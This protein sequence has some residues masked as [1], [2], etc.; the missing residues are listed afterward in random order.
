MKWN[1]FIEIGQ[2]HVVKAT[3]ETRHAPKVIADREAELLF[4]PTLVAQPTL[5]PTMAPTATIIH[6]W[7]LEHIADSYDVT[8]G[9]SNDTWASGYPSDASKLINSNSDV[10]MV[11]NDNTDVNI[12]FDLGAPRL[13]QG[14]YIQSWYFTSI[15]TIEVGV[16]M[17]DG[18]GLKDD[19]END[20][21]TVPDDSTVGWIWFTNIAPIPGCCNHQRTVLIPKVSAR[22]VMIRLRGA[23]S[24]YGSTWG[25]RKVQISGNVDGLIS[26][27][28][29]NVEDNSDPNSVAHIPDETSIVR[30]A[31]YAKSGKLLGVMNMRPPSQQRPLLEQSLTSEVLAPYSTSA[32]SG[33]LPWKWVRE[34]T[35]ILVGTSN[36]EMVAHSLRFHGL[37]H[38]GLHTLTRT[39]VVIFGTEEEFAG[40]DTTTPKAER[41]ATGMFNIMPTSELHWVDEEVWHV[42]Y[43]VIRTS[44]GP[45]V[46]HS[47][48]ERRQALID[49]GD[50]PYHE[51]R[52]EVLKQHFAFRH[53]N[54][55]TGRGLSETDHGCCGGNPYSSGTSI[56]MGWALSRNITDEKWMW[57]H[58][59]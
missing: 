30:L 33:T 52:W 27:N 6:E 38:W 16:H 47:E 22:Y 34:G 4:T 25:V 2:T 59:G 54:A 32:W 14:V 20:M 23:T 41:L 13:I 12:N 46:V 28:D 15:S 18:D 31:A 44:L 17:D 7:G 51:P 43:L 36:G 37:A 39:K 8:L 40:L 24:S 26:N 57:D 58:M 11:S 48:A 35:S 56:F 55:H 19:S 29:T 50:D 45:K 1:G 49:A 9:N 3:G 10:Y 53:R 5:A 42:P 21:H